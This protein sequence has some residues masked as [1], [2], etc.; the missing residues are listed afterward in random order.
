[1]AREDRVRGRE[2]KVK[3]DDCLVLIVNSYNQE[4][5]TTEYQ[6]TKLDLKFTDGRQGYS[7][8]FKFC[9]ECGTEID[10]K[11]IREIQ[12]ERSGA[13]SVKPHGYELAE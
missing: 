10:W 2:P 3:C 4:E 8:K 12:K 7:R 6:A 5:I 13:T 1:M 11:T 9:P